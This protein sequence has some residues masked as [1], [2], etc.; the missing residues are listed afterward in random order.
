MFKKGHSDAAQV[1]L[2]SQM[3]EDQI[4]TQLTVIGADTSTAAAAR[5]QFY[6][7]LEKFALALLPVVVK[8]AAG[9]VTGGIL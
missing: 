1:I 8:L 9:S 3:T 4:K 5:A 6:A 7:D 2:D